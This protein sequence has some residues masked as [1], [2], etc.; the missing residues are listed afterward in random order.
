M[1][2]GCPRYDS[3]PREQK[4]V[5]RRDEKEAFSAFSRAMPR[6]APLIC[7]RFTNRFTWRELVEL[8]RITEP[9]LT[10]VSNL[11]PRYNFARCRA[12]S[13]SGSTGMAAA[14]P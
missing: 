1:G 6:Y 14:C 11:E 8:Y 7:G 13:W 10:P 4:P 5:I 2:R 9:Y 3:A 12:A